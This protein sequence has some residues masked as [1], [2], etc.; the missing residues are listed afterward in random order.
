MDPHERRANLARNLQYLCRSFKSVA[1]ACRHLGVNRQQFNKYLAGKHVPSIRVLSAIS[2]RFSIE[3]EDL[4]RGKAEFEAALRGVEVAPLRALRSS[5]QFMRF[6]PAIANSHA[7]LEPFYGVY[8]RYH[9]SS[10]YKGRILRS[11]VYLYERDSIAQYVCIERFPRLDDGAR[12]AYVFKY[13]GLAL[14]IEDRLFLI[15]FEG[16]QRNEM[17]FSILVPERRNVLRLLYGIVN[18]IAA[19]ALRQPFSTRVALEFQARGPIGRSH[20]KAATALLPSDP[21][22]PLEVRAYLTGKQS[23]IIWAGA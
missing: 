11:A 19:T 18:G 8:Y 22:I 13:H 3:Q 7:L 21:S 2:Q 5:R 1:E 14:M 17:T 9:N 12:V 6:A 20:L 16:I 10:I 23:T 15:D 4:F